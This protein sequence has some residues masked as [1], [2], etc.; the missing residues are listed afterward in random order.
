MRFTNNTPGTISGA[1]LGAF[2]F[3]L[4]PTVT[5][6]VPSLVP[7]ISSDETATPNTYQLQLVLYGALIVVFLLFEPRGLFGLW[8]RLRN[9]WKTWP[10]SY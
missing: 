3:T 6:E 2:F 7:F 8:L 1:I 4:L 10:F 5:R 9:Y